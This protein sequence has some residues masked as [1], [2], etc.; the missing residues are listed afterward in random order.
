MKR[1]IIIFL[2][3]IFINIIIISNVFIQKKAP[4]NV[5]N[6]HNFE[7]MVLVENLKFEFDDIQK[8]LIF[9]IQNS[10]LFYNKKVEVMVKIEG[11]NVY[12]EFKEF[13]VDLDKEE[14]FITVKSHEYNSENKLHV[15]I[16]DLS[17]TSISHHFW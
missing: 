1:R 2:G 9:K 11:D 12:D 6:Q 5:T 14:N 8:N 7:S 13:T 16:K 15:I 4:L 3:I 10:D 17:E